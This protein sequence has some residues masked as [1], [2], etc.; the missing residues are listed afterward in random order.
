MFF[1]CKK[2]NYLTEEQFHNSWAKSISIKDIDVIAQFEGTTS[3]EYKEAIKLLEDVRGRKVLVLGC[4]QGEEAVYL[5][6][7]GAKVTAIDI[8]EEMLKITK[9][10]AKKFNVDK[11]IEYKKMSTEKL[12]FKPK[13]YDK[14]LGC[15]LLH[16]VDIIKTVNEV[17][18]ILK[19]NGIAVFFEPLVYNPIINIYRSMANEVRTDNEHPLSYKDLKNIK[20]IFPDIEHKEF[21]LFTLIIFLWFFIWERL[22]PNKVRY[23]KKI[24]NESEKYK[25]SF[26]LLYFLDKIVLN[27]FPF[28]RRYCWV[29]VIKLK[30]RIKPKTR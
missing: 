16:H 24:I 26:T 12:L 1:V 9:K 23:W 7:L 29:T 5:A 10:L 17:R 30:K 15:N 8:S 25:T 28:L 6:I 22:H 11:R 4:G 21:Q 14:I 2:R 3:P 27:I 19:T 13:S 18:K 20:K